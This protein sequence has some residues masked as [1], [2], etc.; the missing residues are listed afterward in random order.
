MLTH[1]ASSL[2]PINF[3]LK[4]DCFY[5]LN[6]Q[7]AGEVYQIANCVLCLIKQLHTNWQAVNIPHVYRSHKNVT[8]NEIIKPRCWHPPSYN[9]NSPHDVTE[10]KITLMS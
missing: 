1:V 8:L 10:F 3:V 6:L 4:L 5:I 7:Q 2:L 9:K